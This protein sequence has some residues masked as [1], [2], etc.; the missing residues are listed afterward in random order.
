M[1]PLLEKSDL[2]YWGS[3]PALGRIAEGYGVSRDVSGEWLIRSS[4]PDINH[5]VR[6][7]VKRE[8]RKVI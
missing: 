7:L 4:L 2:V 6:F 8:F 5:V 3:G 1:L